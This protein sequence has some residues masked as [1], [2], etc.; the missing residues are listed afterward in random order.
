MQGLCFV[1]VSLARSF[2]DKLPQRIGGNEYPDSY[3][4]VGEFPAFD[5]VV[6]RSARYTERFGDFRNAVRQSLQKIHDGYI[7]INKLISEGSN[8]GAN[9]LSEWNTHLQNRIRLLKEYEDESEKANTAEKKR[10]AEEKYHT[11]LIKERLRYE[12]EARKRAAQDRV[13]EQNCSCLDSLESLP[14]RTQKVLHP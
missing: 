4:K 11:Q 2:G 10:I 12:I 5:E 13:R 1:S 6:Y 14:F 3:P 8:G 9:Q 7:E